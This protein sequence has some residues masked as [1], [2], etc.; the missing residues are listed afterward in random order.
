MRRVGVLMG[1]DENDI[2]AKRWLSGFTEALAQLGWTD[3]RNLR[4]DFVGPPPMSTARGSSR[5]SWSLCDPT[6]SSQQ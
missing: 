6:Q 1:F 5:K 3:G 2:E 4:I